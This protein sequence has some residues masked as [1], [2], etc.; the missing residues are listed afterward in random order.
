MANNQ[1]YPNP[2]NPSTTI[3]Y[4]LQA[5]GRV[6][7]AVFN[8]LGQRIRTLV[9]GRQA[10]GEYAVEW[11]GIDERGNPVGSGVYFYQMK[12]EKFSEIRKMVLIR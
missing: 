3:R 7:L 9:S 12:A 10:A 4:E 5:A 1:N 8:L 6:E 2:F 11:N